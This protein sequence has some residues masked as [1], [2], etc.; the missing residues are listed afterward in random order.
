[1]V[2][3]ITPRPFETKHHFQFRID[4][5]GLG[6]YAIDVSLPAKIPT[7]V[8]LPIILAVDGNLLF[9]IVQTV[10]HGRFASVSESFPASIV[11]GVGYPEEE[12]FAGFY[13]RRNF[14]FHGPWEMN[15]ELGHR[16]HEILRYWEHSEARGKIEMKAG[17]YHLFMAFLRDRLLP[18]LADHFPIDL[19]AHHTLIGDSSGGHF[20]LRALFDRA[21][22]F[23]RYVAVSPSLKTAPGTIE[24]AE[25][26][27]AALSSDLLAD[28]F[29]C[30]GK[31]ELGISR[32]NALCGFGSAVTWC[33]EQMA[34]RQWP[35]LRFA[36]E[37]M[38]NEN[39]I[40][41]T[42]RAISAGLRAVHRLRPGVHEPELASVA[43]AFMKT[44]S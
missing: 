20:A 17:G 33:A 43:S 8:R 12:G 22:P 35:S 21:S 15:D 5:A 27:F 29:V 32:D 18:T 36:C 23:S 41:I 37:V 25:A 7:G 42:P 31:Q 39:H 26:E 44:T 34:L 24:Q 28:V 4:E 9:D 10:V 30:A 38:D 2:K 1:M 16:M 13:A 40:S 3:T 11:V 14:D 19:D 6:T